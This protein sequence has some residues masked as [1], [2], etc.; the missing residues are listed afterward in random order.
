MALE[1]EGAGQV[2]VNGVPPSALPRV[3]LDNPRERKP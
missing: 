3:A 1:E 2:C